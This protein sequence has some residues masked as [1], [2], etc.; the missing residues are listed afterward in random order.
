MKSAFNFLLLTLIAFLCACSPKQDVELV[1]D[2]DSQV[3]SILSKVRELKEKTYQNPISLETVTGYF[4]ENTKPL[5]LRFDSY[6]DFVQYYYNNDLVCIVRNVIGE[7][8][9]SGS[10]SRFYYKKGK[11]FYFVQNKEVKEITDEVE[12]ASKELLVVEAESLKNLEN[13]GKNDGKSQTTSSKLAFM[14]DFVDKPSYDVS[15]DERL[16]AR[17]KVIVKNSDDYSSLISQLAYGDAI[18]K[19]DN[20]IVINGQARQAIDDKGNQVT[21]VSIIVIDLK[22]DAIS[23]GMTDENGNT[24]KFYTEAPSTK[25]PKQLVDWFTK[26]YRGQFKL[27]AQ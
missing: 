26:D 11:L 1:K 5:L 13:K 12:R 7:G 21:F 6:P 19:F 3:D 8:N 15:E 16:T 9:V 27:E 17:L 4:S 25:Y 24:S 22:N 2:I 23:V 10:E 20:T 14:S 18:Q